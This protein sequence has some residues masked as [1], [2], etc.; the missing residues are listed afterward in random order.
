MNQLCVGWVLSLI[1]QAG[2]TT[3]T[4]S[5]ALLLK[6]GLSSRSTVWSCLTMPRVQWVSLKVGCGSTW[7]LVWM[8]KVFCVRLTMCIMWG[9]HSGLSF[10][11]SERTEFHVFAEQRLNHE[12][13]V[14]KKTCG[15]WCVVQKKPIPQINCHG[16]TSKL[17]LTISWTNHV[18]DRCYRWIINGKRISSKL[19]WTSVVS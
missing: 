17:I 9:P 14:H 2:P 11:K 13:G 6:P 16:H 12:G 4:S 1:C 3:H 8:L 18:L 7:G 5:A 10:D 19:I 15:C